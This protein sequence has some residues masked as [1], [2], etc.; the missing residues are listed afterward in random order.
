[1]ICA[2]VYDFGIDDD[3]V[4]KIGS[5]KVVLLALSAILMIT[6]FMVMMM[7]RVM[8]M[9]MISMPMLK[10]LCGCSKWH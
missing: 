7:A 4:L 2:V 1:M 10:I 3:F 6:V 9:M 5:L 8:M